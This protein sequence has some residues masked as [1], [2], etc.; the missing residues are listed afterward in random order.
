[1]PSVLK[2]TVGLSGTKSSITLMVAFSI[3]AGRLPRRRRAVAEHRPPPVHDGLAACG[4]RSPA[5][6]STTCCC[7]SSRRRWSAVIALVTLTVLS[8][9]ACWGMITAYINE[10]FHTGVRASGF[11]LGYSL[12]VILPSFYAG[13][14]DLLSNVMAAHVHAAA[15]ARHRR[16]ADHARRRARAGDAGRRPRR[17]HEGR[18]GAGARAHGPLHAARARAGR[19]GR[20]LAGGTRRDA[21]CGVR[22]GALPGRSSAAA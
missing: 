10:R 16:P 12:A 20:A 4:R 1:M 2:D 14:Q 18:G 3:L 15:A 11:G 21:R 6:R 19:D 22:P 13:Y 9:N 7:R 8:V 17:R 5:R